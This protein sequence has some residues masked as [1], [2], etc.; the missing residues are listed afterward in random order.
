MRRTFVTSEEESNPYPNGSQ[1]F[2][3]AAVTFGYFSQFIYLYNRESNPGLAHDYTRSIQLSYYRD[4]F[5]LGLEPRYT[6]L[7]EQRSVH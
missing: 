4:V 7:E 2:G 5:C 6:T 3:P 1:I